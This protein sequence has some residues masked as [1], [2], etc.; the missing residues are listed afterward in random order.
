MTFWNNHDFELR[1]VDCDNE[2]MIVIRFF[3]VEFDLR[4]EQ[5]KVEFVN[6]VFSIVFDDFELKYKKHDVT[7]FDDNMRWS[8]WNEMLLILMIKK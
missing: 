3:D 1:F 5:M 6:F 7:K 4:F 8:I 2:W